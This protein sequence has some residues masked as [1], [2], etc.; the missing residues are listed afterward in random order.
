MIVNFDDMKEAE[1]KL[2]I[3]AVNYISEEIQV[4]SFHNV[5]RYKKYRQDQIERFIY[6]KQ[7]EGLSIP[8]AA[9]QCGILKSTAYE[10][11][12]EFNS[13][14]GTVLPGNNPRNSQNKAKKLYPIHSEFL[15]QLFDQNPS[16]VLEEA[17][18]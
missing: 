10:L 11:I 16:V 7:E 2:M 3:K 9:A 14:D 18:I 5:K 1:N 13:T 17:R 6:L 4:L 8:K 12:N 15:I